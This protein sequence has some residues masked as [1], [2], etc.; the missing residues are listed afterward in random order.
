M[1][2]VIYQNIFEVT[3]VKVRMVETDGEF[4]NENNAVIMG[5]RY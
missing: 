5:I 4:I 2:N 3:F 1:Q